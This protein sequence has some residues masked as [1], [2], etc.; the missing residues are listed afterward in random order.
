LAVANL[1]DQRNALLKHSEISENKIKLD[2]ISKRIFEI[3][4]E[5]NRN[6]IVKNF[7]QY[8]DNPENI[9][10]QQMWRTLK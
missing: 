3:E 2:E 1:I 8:S 5:E 4:A 10:M 9:N 7:K 6:K